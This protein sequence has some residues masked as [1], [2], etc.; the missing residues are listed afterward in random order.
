MNETGTNRMY[1]VWKSPGVWDL[2]GG[3]AKKKGG[4][5]GL[6]VTW[7]GRW[8]SL[9]YETRAHLRLREPAL[10]LRPV[11]RVA[12]G[13][14]GVVVLRAPPPPM[15]HA[16]RSHIVPDFEV[17]APAPAFAPHDLWERRAMRT[18]QGWALLTPR[19]R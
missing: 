6:R 11:R 5:L 9:E 17:D 13:G 1:G 10:L 16:R 7:A 14:R 3:W 15:R 8:S 2:D 19:H 4:R 12:G 18:L